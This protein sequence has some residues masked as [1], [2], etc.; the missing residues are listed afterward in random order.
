MS[1]NLCVMLLI[2]MIVVLF[3]LMP[4]WYI[5][6]LFLYYFFFTFPELKKKSAI[7]QICQDACITQYSSYSLCEYA[8]TP[9]IILVQCITYVH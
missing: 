9:I 5:L 7:C 8:G 4:T 1:D 2:A 3:V 6:I